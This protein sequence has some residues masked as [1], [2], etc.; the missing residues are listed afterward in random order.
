MF[1]FALGALAGSVFVRWRSNGLYL[2]GAIVAVLGVGFVAVTTLTGSWPAVGA[3]FADSRTV[4]VVAWLLI[5]VVVSAVIGY[6][7]LRRAPS[8]A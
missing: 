2:L 8:R 5:P 4:G 6:F 3:W 1:C 7:V